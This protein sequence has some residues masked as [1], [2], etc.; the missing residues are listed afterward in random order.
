[1]G[2]DFPLREVDPGGTIRVALYW[3]ALRGM[4]DDYLMAVE[5]RDEAGDVCA[6][7]ADRP[8][9]GTYPTTRWEEGEVLRDWHDLRVPATTAQGTYEVYVQ[10]RDGGAVLGELSLGQVEVGGRPHYFTAPQ[11]GHQ[12]GVK[13]GDSVRLLGYDVESD[14]VKAGDV[15]RLALYWEAAGEMEV[16]YTVF[17]HLIDA[18]HRIWAQKDS[19]PGNGLVPTNSWVLGEVITDVYELEI[20]PNAPPGDYVLEIGMYDAATGQ[21]LQVYDLAGAPVGDRVL[22]ESIALLP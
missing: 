5:L 13:V 6:E 4:H 9:D 22:S 14:Q 10:V 16:S 1:M 20:D 11:I 3:Q 21:R 19:V 2:Y 7:Q 15:L 8:V 12:L 17:T 18:S